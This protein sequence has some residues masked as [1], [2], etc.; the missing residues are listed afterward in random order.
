MKTLFLFQ[1]FRD[2]MIKELKMDPIWV[3]QLF[4]Q[5]DDLVQIHMAFLHQLRDL[6]R[7]R[8]DNYVEEIGPVLVSQVQFS[9]V[10][11]KTTICICENKDADQLCGNREADQRLFSLHG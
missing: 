11:R 9:H 8:D 5:L 3:D 4:P 1:F 6:Q 10:M 7:K 2:G